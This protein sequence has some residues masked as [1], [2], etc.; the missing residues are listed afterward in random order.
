MAY[1]AIRRHLAISRHR[2]IARW[3]VLGIAISISA[4]T[5][6]AQPSLEQAVK[7]SYLFKFGPFVDWPANAFADSGGAF[8]ICIIGRDPF[9]RV[10]DEVVRGQKIHG[11]P[12]LVRRL[13]KGPVGPCHILY[14]GDQAGTG[15][16]PSDL[17]AKPV[18]TVSDRSEGK[19]NGMIQFVMQGG[20]VRFAIDGGAAR[21]SGVR[22]SS[23]LLDL[24]VPAD[25]K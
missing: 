23:K 15:E 22:I 19:G 5:S 10:L 6:A 24:A 17:I 13:S 18:L 7:A 20:R 3:L 14:L 9:G 2:R 25:T 16:L 8:Q 11:R 1:L 12:A 4:K 21:A